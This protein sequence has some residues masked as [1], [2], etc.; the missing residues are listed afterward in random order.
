MSTIV[1]PPVRAVATPDERQYS[2]DMQYYLQRNI[3]PE[4]L[5]FDIGILAGNLTPNYIRVPLN[6][7]VA[8]KLRC[9]GY[10]PGTGSFRV[11]TYWLEDNGTVHDCFASPSDYLVMGTAS[12]TLVEVPCT[13]SVAVN[14]FESTKAGRFL[15]AIDNFSGTQ[16]AYVVVEQILYPI[17][18]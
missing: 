11:H 10:A 9:Y 8:T 4:V 6:P 7:G 17:S 12:G 16:W 14:P 15:V 2:A 3:L 13:G 18:Q 5:R 1:V